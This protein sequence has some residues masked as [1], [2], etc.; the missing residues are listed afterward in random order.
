[1]FAD[2]A[3]FEDL[4][5][6]LFEIIFRLQTF[7]CSIFHNVTKKLKFSNFLLKLSLASTP[8]L[9]TRKSLWSEG[10]NENIDFNC[11][12]NPSNY[13][14]FPTHRPKTIS[15]SCR[16]QKFFLSVAFHKIMLSSLALEKN[17]EWKKLSVKKSLTTWKLFIFAQ[18]IFFFFLFGFFSFMMRWQRRKK[19]HVH[20]RLS[21]S[22]SNNMWR[23]RSW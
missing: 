17:H 8:T 23:V 18:N 12:F 5:F 11:N 13:F 6:Q 2:L 3:N 19:S 22:K 21:Y 15:K 1:M 10:G 20:Y 7:S 4:M 9:S 16:H 14:V